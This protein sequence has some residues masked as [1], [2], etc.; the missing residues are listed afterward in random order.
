MNHKSRL[1]SG[2]AMQRTRVK[3]SNAI[4]RPGHRRPNHSSVVVDNFHAPFYFDV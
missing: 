2:S 3:D 1:T 4:R